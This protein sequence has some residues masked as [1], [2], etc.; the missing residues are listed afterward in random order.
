MAFLGAEGRP[1]DSFIKFDVSMVNAINALISSSY[2]AHFF[3]FNSLSLHVIFLV[4][5]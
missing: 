1:P 3:R 4:F 5:E 2:H